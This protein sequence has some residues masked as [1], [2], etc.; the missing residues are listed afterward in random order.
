[1]H[2][3]EEGSRSGRPIDKGHTCRLFN[4]RTCPGELRHKER[5]YQAEHPPI[6]RREPWDSV[7][8]IRE[9]NG[10][11]RGNRTRA[12]VNWPPKNGRHE[13]WY[14]GPVEVL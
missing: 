11:V 3:T 13:V 12:R 10:R 7:H 4:D 2:G 14:F 6:I 9:T 5:R 1:M 8:A